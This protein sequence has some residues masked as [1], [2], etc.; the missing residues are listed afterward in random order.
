MNE[1]TKFLVFANIS[2]KGRELW[3]T[4]YDPPE[5][6]KSIANLRSAGVKD[7]QLT[8]IPLTTLE[9]AERISKAFR[10]R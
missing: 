4:I 2:G 8:E 1:P 7:I 10:V 5:V 9:V 3:D 6:L